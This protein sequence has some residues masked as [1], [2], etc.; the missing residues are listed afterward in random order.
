MVAIIVF[1]GGA[2]VAGYSVLSWESAG[3][4]PLE[5]RQTMRVAIPAVTLMLSG[6]LIG[7][8]SFTMWFIATFVRG[9]FEQ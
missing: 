4:G 1:A 2:L 7:F 9:R 6:A 5:P 3:F 8:F